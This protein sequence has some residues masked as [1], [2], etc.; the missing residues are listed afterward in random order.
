[1]QGYSYQFIC[2]L[3]KLS[4]H[5]PEPLNRLRADLSDPDRRRDLLNAIGQLNGVASEGASPRSQWGSVPTGPGNVSSQEVRWFSK[6]LDPGVPA[7]ES[8][9]PNPSYRQIQPPKKKRYPGPSSF[10]DIKTPQVACSDP[11]VIEVL[12]IIREKLTTQPSLKSRRVLTDLAS[13]LDVSLAKRDSMPRIVQKIL[14]SLAIRSV[15]DIASALDRVKEADSG[16]TESFMELATFI[17]HGA[18]N[19]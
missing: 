19:N 9:L 15:D 1:M 11:E 3:S 6:V 16:S 5:G 18:R 14:D 12:N 7:L 4:Q 8:G 2:D 17:T 13:L 10:D